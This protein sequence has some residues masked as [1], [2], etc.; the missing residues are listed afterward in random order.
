LQTNP[1][2]AKHEN[3]QLPRRLI[4][5]LPEESGNTCYFSSLHDCQFP[6]HKFNDR[7]DME[8]QCA[9]CNHPGTS[10]NRDCPDMG[11]D[12]KKEDIQSDTANKR[13]D[14]RRPGKYRKSFGRTVVK[15]KRGF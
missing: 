15:T 1:A 13:R 6:L 12:R 3:H 2:F 11:P 8:R 14:D 5:P 4:V 7:V 9:S 10:I